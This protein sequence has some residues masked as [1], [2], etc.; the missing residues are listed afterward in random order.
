MTKKL[1]E[2]AAKELTTG[3]YK[4]LCFMDEF[5][6]EWDNLPTCR[7]ICRKFNV[8]STASAH[9]WIQGLVDKGFIEKFGGGKYRFARK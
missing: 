7:E 3:E 9:T 1:K 2:S 6:K 4:C 8:K 5:L